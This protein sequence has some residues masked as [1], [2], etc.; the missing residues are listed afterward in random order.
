[1]HTRKNEHQSKSTIGANGYFGIDVYGHCRGR[2]VRVGGIGDE[3]VG[4]GELGS[5]GLGTGRLGSEE[6]GTRGRRARG[7]QGM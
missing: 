7:R 3:G 4:V 5:E 1:M 2:G 6:L